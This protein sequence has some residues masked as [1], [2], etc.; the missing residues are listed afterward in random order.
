M[1]KKQFD[2]LGSVSSLIANVRTRSSI[3]DGIVT[4]L[5]ES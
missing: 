1:G 2:N 3:E 4:L 5:A